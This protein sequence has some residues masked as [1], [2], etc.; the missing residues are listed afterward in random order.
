MIPEGGAAIGKKDGVV[1]GKRWELWNVKFFWWE[2]SVQTRI[3]G[4]E[5]I[6]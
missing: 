4:I 6:I 2:K 3:H 5:Y 1:F